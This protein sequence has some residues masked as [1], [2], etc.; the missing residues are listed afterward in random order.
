VA[1]LQ[2]TVT[3]IRVADVYTNSGTMDI[4]KTSTTAGDPDGDPVGLDDAG[5]VVGSRLGVE[6]V[7]TWVG[8]WVGSEL[9]G[10]AEGEGEG[11][12]VTIKHG[13]LISANGVNAKAT[14]TF[15]VLA[16]VPAM[17]SWTCMSNRVFSIL[18]GVSCGSPVLK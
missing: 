14:P 17:K 6:V 1:V 4:C 7:G 2:V 18:F 15:K 13:S 10:A 8:T 3:V 16:P 5:E 9:A 11:D 12:A